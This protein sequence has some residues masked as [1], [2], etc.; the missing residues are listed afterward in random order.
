MTA[1]PTIE[2][3]PAGDALLVKAVSQ[4]VWGQPSTWIALGALVIS[5]A[6]FLLTA[7]DKW[8]A[9]RKDQ[10]SR[11]Q[12]IHDEFWL[13]K[14]LF[15]S[16]IEPAMNFAADTM[17]AL[18]TF[19]HGEQ[20]WMDYFL[21]FQAEHRGHAR[22]LILVATM[23]PEVYTKLAAEFEVIEDAVA[24]YCNSVSANPAFL[25]ATAHTKATNAVGAALNAFCVAIR[26]HQTTIGRT[27]KS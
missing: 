13:R 10:R 20:A 15:P 23:W 5:C 7:Y 12:S 19:Q 14:V 18:P 27:S 24:E 1:I 21:Q 2:I 6:S 22:K 8:N 25:D 26:D 17:T 4:S 3:R 11:E 16:A 9:H